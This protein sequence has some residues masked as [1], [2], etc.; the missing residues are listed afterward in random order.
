V[1]SGIIVKHTSYHWLFW[2]PLIVIAVATV[3]VHVFVPESPVRVPGKVN[4]RAAVLLSAGPTVI[5]ITTS[6][7]IMWGWGSPKTLGML[8][9]GLVLLAGWVSTDAGANE[10]LV[11]MRMMRLREE[12]WA[13]R[14]PPP[15]WPPTWAW[16]VSRPVT[17][18]RWLL[19]SAPVPSSLVWGQR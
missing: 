14:S 12:R 4:W 18:T 10:P 17:A 7:A 13:G 5:L 19:V 6:E 11:D 16:E 1:L 3:A 2:F 8:V 9:V 15:C